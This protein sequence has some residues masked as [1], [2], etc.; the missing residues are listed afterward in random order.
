MA[1][2]ITSTTAEELEERLIRR[3]AGI[4]PSSLKH[5]G[6]G[7]TPEESNREVGSSLQ[8]RAFTVA[9]A[10]GEDVPEGLTGNADAETEVVIQVIVDYRLVVPEDLGTMVTMDRQDLTDRLCDSWDPVIPGMTYSEFVSMESVEEED[11]QRVAY[12]YVVNYMR[13]RRT[14]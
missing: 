13:A 1:E 11:L 10:P 3:I 6:E 12:T 14:T 4:V 7:W 8:T 2:L 5:R 9:M